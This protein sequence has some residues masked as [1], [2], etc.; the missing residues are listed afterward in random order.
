MRARG[1]RRWAAAAGVALW[2]AH[3]AGAQPGPQRFEYS[4]DAMGGT[5]SIAVFAGTRAQADAATSAAFDELRRL[6][7]MLSHYRPGSEWSQ[8]NRDAAQRAVHVPEELFDLVSA[9]IGYSER[10]E[11]AF[12]IT[13]G[14]LVRAW[15]FHDGSGSLPEPEAV[16]QAKA[17]VGYRHVLLDQAR[18]TIRLTRPGVAL[19]PGGIGK[20]YAVDRMVVVLRAH[21]V[22]RALVSAA[23]SSLYALGAPPGR[24]GWPVTIGGQAA[25]SV[26]A[27]VLLRDES[28]S[29]S[30]SLAKSFE[31]KGRTYGH[32]I[33]PRTGAP[34]ASTLAAVVAPR[35]IDSEAWT[36]AVLVNGRAWASRH[37]PDGWRALLCEDNRPSSCAWVRS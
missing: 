27:R 29:T 32:V 4:A 12:D 2:L 28:L 36:K 31:A 3:G 33:D 20:G 19:D 9:A 30:G 13:V 14:P 35:A 34:V 8:V 18:R 11:G 6:D 23:R 17:R 5:F 10:S 1:V 15:G 26:E 21:G 16:R 22:D 7:R 37:T 25:A 24:D